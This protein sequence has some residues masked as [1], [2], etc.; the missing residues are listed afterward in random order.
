MILVY[1][2]HLDMPG[3]L[4]LSG[5]KYFCKHMKI[6]SNNKE[7]EIKQYKLLFS[8]NLLTVLD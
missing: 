7:S 1:K 4:Y 6:L 5:I 2:V 3:S 8:L